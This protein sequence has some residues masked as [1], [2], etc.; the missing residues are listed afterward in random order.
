M[1]LSLYKICPLCRRQNYFNIIDI[2][3][4]NN[5]ECIICYDNLD[6]NICQCK[7]CKNIFHIECIKQ[8][9][10]NNENLIEIQTDFENLNNIEN[11]S[12]NICN[13]LC[14]L[15]I[16][17]KLVILFYLLTIIIVYIFSTLHFVY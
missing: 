4:I 8:I 13:N 16:C 6:T 11:I 1:N 9:K 7:T 17:I 15:I 14:K 10:N 3:I 12:N 5:D 2:E